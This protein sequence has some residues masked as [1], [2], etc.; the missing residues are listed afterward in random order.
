MTTET[1]G[2]PATAV[3]TTDPVGKRAQKQ[4]VSQAD[5][6]AFSL[7]D[8]LRVV[9][10]LAE[11]Y[12]L[13][14]ASPLDVARAI[15]MQP[16]SGTFR[17]LIGA[18]NSYGLT[19]GGARSDKISVTPLGRRVVRPTAEGEELAA[20][21]EAFLRPR[22]IGMF[23]KQFDGGKVPREDLAKNVLIEKMDVP[24]AEAQRVF[25]QIV[26]DARALSLLVDIKGAEYVQLASVRMPATTENAVAVAARAAI[27]VGEVPGSME[28]LW[29]EESTGDEPQ[30]PSPVPDPRLSR[31][32]VTHGTNTAFVELLKKFLKFG[33]LEAVVAVERETSAVPVPQKVI[34]DMRTCGAAIIHVDA[35]RTLIDKDGTEHVVLNENVLI[36]IGVAMGL[37]G[38]RFVLLVR[39]GVSLP[40]NMQGLYQVRYAG[41]TL[42][43]ETAMKLLEAITDIKNRS[44]P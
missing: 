11:E 25:G 39:E 3:G 33:E 29:S 2:A 22:V 16:G 28:S 12:N 7:G 40:S 15:R 43:A 34:G 8:T 36:E 14:P 9:T 23:L 31:V 13:Q 35:E 10:A 21:R 4:N 30:I 27:P 5:V 17:M 41:E 19:E 37:Y 38:E 1:K 24:V 26:K 18:S 6:P 42:D 44:L 32:F 20:K